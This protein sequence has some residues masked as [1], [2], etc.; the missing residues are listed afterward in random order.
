MTHGGEG[1]LDRVAGTDMLPVLGRKVVERQ[2]RLA[3]L[4]QT[5]GSLIIF[6]AIF[7]QEAV[8]RLLCLGR[9]KVYPERSP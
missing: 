4:G 9:A 5:V 2:Q 1:T 7:G 6:G 3:V 8:E